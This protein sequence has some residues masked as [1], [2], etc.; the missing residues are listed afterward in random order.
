MGLYFSSTAILILSYALLLKSRREAP[1][2][3]RRSVFRCERPFSSFTAFKE[4]SLSGKNH[5]ILILLLPSAHPFFTPISLSLLKL[6]FV[7]LQILD[8]LTTAGPT[9]TYFSS[10]PGS[11]QSKSWA[12]TGEGSGHGTAHSAG[13][14]C[15]DVANRLGQGAEERSVL[16]HRLPPAITL[17][18]V[19]AST[20][21]ERACILPPHP[22]TGKIQ[23]NLYSWKVSSCLFRKVFR[24]PLGQILL[25]LK[26]ERCFL[27]LLLEK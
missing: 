11:A 21:N 17:N 7:D 18:F 15:P 22:W 12:G 2:P 3:K 23:F 1:Q 4:V 10:V 16:F 25:A 19:A 9:Q 24:L 20:G 14:C 26:R 5:P 27:M 8:T 6:H 13:L